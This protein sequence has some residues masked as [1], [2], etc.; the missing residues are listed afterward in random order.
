VADEEQQR[1]Q[2]HPAGTS[3][4]VL[5]EHPGLVLLRLGYLELIGEKAAYLDVAMAGQ[6]WS[7]AVS[8]LLRSGDR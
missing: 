7:H 5:A 6:Q 2:Q 8:A 3:K 4:Q 1:Q